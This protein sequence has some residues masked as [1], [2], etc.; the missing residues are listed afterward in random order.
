MCCGLNHDHIHSFAESLGREVVA[1]SL[2]SHSA[3]DCIDRECCIVGNVHAHCLSG[4]YGVWRKYQSGTIVVG[5]DCFNAGVVGLYVGV[6]S[7]QLRYFNALGHTCFACHVKSDATEY[8]GECSLRS[9][10]NEVANVK[11]HGVDSRVGECYVGS[12]P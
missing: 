4:A 6:N 2:Q 12:F 11:I 5:Y 9:F 7:A 10:T 8:Y 3:I 1:H